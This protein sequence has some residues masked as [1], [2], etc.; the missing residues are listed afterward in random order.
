VRLSWFL[1]WLFSFQGC[2]ATLRLLYSFFIGHGRGGVAM[3]VQAVPRLRLSDD[4]DVL[5]RTKN[6]P[7]DALLQACAGRRAENCGFVVHDG[8]GRQVEMD[9]RKVP[10]ILTHFTS[11]LTCHISPLQLCSAGMLWKILS[12]G[13]IGSIAYLTICLSWILSHTTWQVSCSRI[14]R[15]LRPGRCY[16]CFGL[17]TEYTQSQSG[18]LITYWS[19]DVRGSFSFRP[20]TVGGNRKEGGSEWVHRKSFPP[21]KLEFSA[22]AAWHRQALHVEKKHIL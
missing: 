17:R 6:T 18:F 22:S 3:L 8:W 13:G 12:I 15:G 9:V 20:K 4:P 1:M 11:C 5:G 21:A 14:V 10:R 19:C 7:R 2:G 16:C